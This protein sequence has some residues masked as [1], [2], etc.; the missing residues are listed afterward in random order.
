M[1]EKR[2]RRSFSV[3]IRSQG[4]DSPAEKRLRNLSR[5]SDRLLNFRLRGI[6][7]EYKS[8]ANVRELV[9][10]ALS[11]ESGAS[12]TVYSL[13]INPVDHSNQVATLSFHT[14]PDRLSG[15]SRNEWVFNLPADESS[16]E[17]GFSLRKPLIFD[18]HFKGF[19]SLHQPEDE[20]C[21]VE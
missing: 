15:G 8:R 9:K 4:G 18:T 5:T 21:H 7:P 13:V 17:S 11:I 1:A 12:V 14:L 19:T 3:E 6:P 10:T 16:D 20:D 2:K